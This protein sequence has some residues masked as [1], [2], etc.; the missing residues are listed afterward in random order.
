MILF[1]AD[2][3]LG[4]TLYHTLTEENITTAETD[5]R[6]ALDKI[7]ERA[8]RRDIDLIICAGDF[9]HS[10]KPTTESIRWA[11]LWFEKMDALGKP[12]FILPGN[13]DVGALSSS[14]R[15]MYSLATLKHTHIVEWEMQHYIWNNWNLYFIPFLSATSLKN[16]YADTLVLYNEVVQ[17]ASHP[18][19]MQQHCMFITHLQESQSTLG[20]ERL[21]FAK[22]VEIVDLNQFAA[23]EGKTLFLSGHMHSHQAYTKA[24]GTI[25]AYP[26]STTYMESL[27]CGQ[28][29][30]YLIIDPEGI[31]TFEP[32]IGIRLFK[33][34]ALPKGKDAVEFFSYTRM[35]PNEVIF[36]DVMAGDIVDEIKLRQFL[37]ERGSVVG[38]INYTLE[39]RDNDGNIV[40]AP[41]E[42]NPLF[43]LESYLTQY[44]Y[45][46]E[47]Y[48]WKTQILPL[49]KETIHAVTQDRS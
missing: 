10:P 17:Q 30:G 22:A 43:H 15:F 29:K 25:V 39:A 24:N 12:F 28:P 21:L 31:I 33:K 26:G 13:H 18:S 19:K 7:Y 49:G 47:G 27:D 37:K 20:A 38:K 4:H 45:K 3:H 40:I 1:F 46:T 16:K 2:P 42:N 5:S 14:L 23:Q 44:K 6:I 32:I 36:L 8:S 11:I 9:F 35:L 34:Y 41:S 48:D